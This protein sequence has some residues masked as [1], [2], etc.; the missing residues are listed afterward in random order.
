MTGTEF[1]ADPDHI[2]AY[3]PRQEIRQNGIR[4][5]LQF[6]ECRGVSW[7][8]EPLVGDG[9]A[10]CGRSTLCL[11]RRANHR[12][13]NAKTNGYTRSYPDSDSHSYTNAR[14]DTNG[15]TRSYPDADTRSYPNACADTNGYTRS[16]PDAGS[17]SYPNA[18]ACSYAQANG[19]TRFYTNAYAQADGYACSY[20][21]SDTRSSK[22]L[23]RRDF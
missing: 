16:Y 19:H 14:A 3:P 7:A 23:Y 17:R 21:D 13:S 6:A 11:R 9:M 8:A 15:Y 1:G 12:R 2:R 20:P 4:V 10:A 18:C 22:D 5:S